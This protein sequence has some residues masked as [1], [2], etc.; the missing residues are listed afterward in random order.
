M[1]DHSTILNH[2]SPLQPKQVMNGRPSRGLGGAAS[3]L[4][5]SFVTFIK[6]MQY[7]RMLSVLNATSTAELQDMG[8]TRADIPRHAALL[9]NYE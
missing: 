6:R 8:L 4:R 3:T 9:V 5:Q 2:A 7:H 1:A